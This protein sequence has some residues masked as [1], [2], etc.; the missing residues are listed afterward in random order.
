[1]NE[2]LQSMPTTEEVKRAVMGLNK[3][4]AAG[5]DGMSG[6]FSN[7]LGIPQERIFV[8]WSRH[9]SV[10]RSYRGSLLTRI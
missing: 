1:M 9:S 5:P 10:V 6:A 7:I 3:N 2:E 4:S 8:I